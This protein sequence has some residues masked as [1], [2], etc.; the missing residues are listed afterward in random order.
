MDNL[1]VI[2]LTDNWITNEQI[3]IA[4]QET[5]KIW[6]GT[7]LTN[8]VRP[9]LQEQVFDNLMLDNTSEC[10]E[11][12]DHN[13][14]RIANAMA[15]YAMDNNLIDFVEVRDRFTTTLRGTLNVLC[16]DG[17]LKNNLEEKK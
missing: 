12:I 4:V 9:L 17:Y 10:A 1:L 7:I 16:T 15:M 3:R 14:H 8:A 5:L 6:G 13:K 2:R 11:F